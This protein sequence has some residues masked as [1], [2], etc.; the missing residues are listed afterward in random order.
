MTIEW[1]EIEVIQ[2]ETEEVSLSIPMGATS[3]AVIPSNTDPNHYDL[4]RFGD[5]ITTLILCEPLD[6]IVSRLRT[7]ISVWR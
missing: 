3:L 1:A 2:D 7:S 5:E 6:R 4:V